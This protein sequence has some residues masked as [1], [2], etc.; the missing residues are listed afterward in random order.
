MNNTNTTNFD[1]FESLLND[2][3]ISSSDLAEK[4]K[5]DIDPAYK[6]KKRYLTFVERKAKMDE[7]KRQKEE[8]IKQSTCMDLPIGFE[9][10]FEYDKRTKGVYFE[11]IPDALVHCYHELGCVDIEYIA[12][13][14]KTSYKNVIQ[15]LRGSIFQ[16]PDK[17]QECFYK[18]W[19]IAEEY[20][21][22]NLVRKYMSAK[23]ANRVYKNWFE[24]NLK[25][26]E[27]LLPENLLD[28]D[29]YVHPAAPW[30]PADVH[31]EFI[32]YLFG[33]PI[34][35]YN[36]DS[37]VKHDEK[38]ST[39]DVPAKSLYR[40]NPDVY[41]KYGTRRMDALE[42]YEK[43]LN[44]SPIKVTD[45]IYDYSKAK[46]VRILNQSETVLAVEKQ[47]I[48]VKAFQ[49]WI[50]KDAQRK[51][52]LQIIF[53]EKYGY[54]RRRKF[55]GS[56]LKFPG[57][58][59]DIEL[60]PYQK[61]A[62]ARIIFS[63]NV[64]LAHDVGSGKTYEL[65]AAGMELKRMGLSKKNLYVVPNNILGQWETLF[66]LLYEEAKVMC[67][68]PKIFTPE[69]RDETLAN[70]R[71]NDYDAI[72]MPYSVFD[73]I[74][75]SKKWVYERF[76]AEE[77][78]LVEYS[79]NWNKN[80]SGIR[81]AQKNL[82]SDTRKLL[83]KVK[84]FQMSISFDELGITRLFVDEAHNYKNVP[85]ETKNSGIRGINNVGSLKCEMMLEKVRFIQKMNNGAGVVMATGTP[86][87]NSL[88]DAFVMQ[89]YL[90]SGELALLD[91]HTF[92]AWVGMFAEA[93]TDFEIDVDTNTYRLAT[94]LSQFHNMTEL[95][96]LLS[97]I[98][99]FHSM[100]K[101]EDIPAFNGYTDHL[102]PQTDELKKYLQ[103][104]SRRADDIHRRRV[105]RSEDN[106]LL[107]TVDGRKAALD[108][109]LVDKGL[110]LSSDSKVYI[111]ANE[112][113]K[114]YHE[115]ME[116]KST[117]LVFCDMSTPSE[118]FNLY[119]EL[120]RILIEKGIPYSQLAFIH[121]AKTEIQREKL[122]DKVRKGDVRVLIGSTL[123]LGTGVN[124]Q[125]KLIAIHHFDIP[126]RPSDMVQRQ[127]RILRQGN[128]NSE[129][130][131][132]RYI[133]QGSFDAYSWQ[134]LEVKQRFINEILSG[135]MT[136]KEISDIDDTVL[137]YAEVKALAVGNPLIKQRVEVANELSRYKTLQRKSR[138]ERELLQKE[139]LEI[140]N[141]REYYHARI[142][143]TKEDVAYVSTSTEKLDI[144][145]RKELRTNLLNALNENDL[146]L[147]EKHFGYYRG[148]EIVLPSHMLKGQAF[149]W[150]QRCG[151]YR[152][153][154]ADN[155]KGN[156]MRI[157]NCIDGLKDR[158]S[159]FFDRLYEIRMRQ[160]SIESQLSKKESYLKEIS[161]CEKRLRE[162][163]KELGVKK[164]A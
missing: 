138:E 70:I 59:P 116:N 110:S 62:V 98:A 41:S 133:T 88:T 20:L 159:R 137:D 120:A 56:F 1:L 139:L 105:S 46:S 58:N 12:A 68:D 55:D 24:D 149:V 118:K 101:G 7:E 45:E 130:Y 102:I 109:R 146:E 54:Y 136:V 31:D 97:S 79:K 42:I 39:W 96:A 161:A 66:H 140:P 150:I 143:E 114:I 87:T 19:E 57:L 78:S 47:K 147:Q 103:D 17:W 92:D 135:S 131:I 48:L 121:D 64:L 107:L 164:S 34:R 81:R 76:L 71:D 73:K 112:I 8:R 163:D 38:T 33:K 99:D 53:A 28:E 21:T 16:N 90:Q 129:V 108:M 117:Q 153:D 35:P 77:E 32:Q 13:V 111:C 134:L 106:M 145:A 69:K 93:V 15:A 126:W 94:R 75:I 74:P 156:L 84:K 124:V 52:R 95:T 91:I 10:H 51:Q 11:S 6:I 36:Y 151:R 83:E 141:Q 148:F 122:F 113:I 67:V 89:N 44:G 14:T 43:T 63:P 144:D 29:I 27:Q 25:A 60:Y 158:L 22:G 50:W 65:I 128:S 72:I 127:G 23:R 3:N 2:D 18:G 26:I 61:D 160:E 157:D 119:N 85:V 142:E 82:K 155:E 152:V 100:E 132:H 5:E 86:L 125:D 154:M 9:N 37:H 115:T 162:I 30:I 80:T 49:D 104:I 40:N 123:K 4:I